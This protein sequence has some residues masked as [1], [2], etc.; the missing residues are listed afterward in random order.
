MTNAQISLVKDN[1]SRISHLFSDEEVAKVFRIKTTDLSH[2]DSKVF[3]HA[4]HSIKCWSNVTLK[5]SERQ[6][7]DGW[8]DTAKRMIK[9]IK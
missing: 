3:V 6:I 1:I 8:V 4:I 9:K 2:N 5:D 7:Y